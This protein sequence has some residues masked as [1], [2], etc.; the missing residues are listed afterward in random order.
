MSCLNKFI[1]KYIGEGSSYQMQVPTWALERMESKNFK[2]NNT[3][4]NSSA[5]TNNSKNI[6]NK[7]IGY[8]VI[9]D[10]PG[11][12]KSFKNIYGKYGIQK[13]F[14]GS[15]MLKEHPCVT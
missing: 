12:G 10:M 13:Y 4:N 6:S 2:Q 7:S 15:R 1:T 11:L 9:P 8:I 14:N 5:N 3:S